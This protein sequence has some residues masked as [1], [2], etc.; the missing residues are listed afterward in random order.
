MRYSAVVIL[1]PIKGCGVGAN[2][3]VELD[4]D[5]VVIRAYDSIMAGYSH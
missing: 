4:Q 2:T 3:S 5:A 1:G